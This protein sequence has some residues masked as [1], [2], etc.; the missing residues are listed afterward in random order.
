[1]R[2]EKNLYEKIKIESKKNNLNIK[3]FVSISC[4]KNIDNPDLDFYLIDENNINSLLFQI[5]KIGVNINQIARKINS[6]ELIE[7]N[8]IEF[9]ERIDNIEKEIN[10]FK[11]HLRK[12]K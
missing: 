12:I 11:Q 5:R 9:K 1:M 6:N 2:L 4:L 8:F 3:D 7:Y 10:F